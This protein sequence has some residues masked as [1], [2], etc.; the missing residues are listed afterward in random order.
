MSLGL[1]EV[2][3]STLYQNKDE[4][5]DVILRLFM[6]CLIPAFLSLRELRKIADKEEIPELTKTKNFDDMC[7]SLWS[8]YKDRMQSV[9]KLLGYDIGFLFQRDSLFEQGCDDFLRAHPEVN[10]ELISRMKGNRAKWQ[11]DLLRFRNDY[12]EHQTIKREDVASLYSLQ[13]AEMFFGNVWVA[14]EEILV[15]L[16]AA[17]LPPMIELREIPESERIPS[18]PK[19]FGWA[20][21]NPPQLP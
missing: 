18:L 20:L 5:K 6:E 8:A 21:A 12:L 13:H 1:I 4:I 2:L 7:K 19:R 17:K 14:I 11:P 16:M 10:A 3:D 15:I 9:A